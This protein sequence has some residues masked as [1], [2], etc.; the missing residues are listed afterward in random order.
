[1]STKVKISSNRDR[2]YNSRF[3]LGN[4][5][6]DLATE[7]LGM[8]KCK[9]VTS[10]YLKGEI[11][12]T[13]NADYSHLVGL[14]DFDDRV[15]AMMQNQHN[16]AQEAFT[17]EQSAPEKSKAVYAAEI[18][19]FM[20]SKNEKAALATA[21]EALERFG[22]DP[23]FSSFCGLLTALV[24]NKWK[25]GAKLCQ[26][27]IGV[28]K[29]SQSTDMAYF[30]PLFYLHLGRVFL[31]GNRRR[32]AMDAFEVGLKYDRDNSELL[33]GIQSFGVRRSPVIPFLPRSN[34]INIYLGK[35]RHRLK[36]E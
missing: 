10:I 13:V 4:E 2:E 29:K 30:L 14:P 5:T 9:I 8:K 25:E 36:S 35:V 31:I 16:L 18:R 23:F 24:E 28:L 26:D 17:R 3:Q 15:R 32:N 7:D 6:Y 27:A 21:R 11:L 33:A 20:S 22:G 1:M 12:S 19:K 34:P